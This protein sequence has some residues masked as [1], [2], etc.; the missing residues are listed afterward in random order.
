[1][2][3]MLVPAILA[4]Q[5]FSGAKALEWTRKAVAFGPRPAGSAAIAKLQTMIRA[6]L[7][8]QGW[9]VSEDGFTAG[10][11]VGP[12]V[13]RNIIAKQNGTSGRMIVLTG[14]YDTKAIP[15]M[16]FVGANDGGASAGWLLEAARALAKLPRKHDV[17]LVFFDGEEAFGEWSDTNGI[18]GSRHLAE[19]WRADGTL[20]R[21]HALIN[22]DMIGDADLKVVDEQNSSP[23]LRR[24]LRTAA[25]ETGYG[26]YFPPQGIAI[27]DD[28]MPF[29]RLGVNAVDLI[30]FDYGPGHSYWH[31]AKDT[32]DKLSA[33]SLQVVGDVVM[34]VLRRLQM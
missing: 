18:Y 20:T 24:L 14:H 16:N 13:M 15:G 31:T 6:E 23:A 9:Q 22:I 30:D 3:L 25:A 11:P 2:M 10:T 17:A 8:A 33:H 1:M 34:E 7:T 5:D 29:V 26:K 21:I 28:H 4:A 12:K 32:V 27:E 19:K